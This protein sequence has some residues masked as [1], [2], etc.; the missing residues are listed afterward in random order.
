MSAATCRTMTSSIPTV[1]APRRAI[2]AGHG[3]FAV[4][5]V[6]AVQQISGKGD[7]FRAVSSRDLSAVA[8][9][10]LLRATIDAHGVQVIFTDLPAGSCTIAAR[11]VA[12]DMPGVV[13]VTGTN[14]S[15]LL[16]WALGTEDSAAAWSHALERGRGAMV[17]FPAAESKEGG[18][19]H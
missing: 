2:V 8:I 12:R 1:A 10:E 3:D 5:M 13:V 6:S 15:I 4:G 7:T 19:G 9:E 18:G 16:S 11:R 14:L 17:V